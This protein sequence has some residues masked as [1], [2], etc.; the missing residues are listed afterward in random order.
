MA[1][2]QLF[3]RIQKMTGLQFTKRIN[4]EFLDNPNNWGSRG[5][6]PLHETGACAPAGRLERWLLRWRVGFVGL[7]WSIDDA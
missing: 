4:Q 2:V 7:M 1:S 6:F 5:E 3:M